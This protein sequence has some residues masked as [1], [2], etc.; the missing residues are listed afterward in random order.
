MATGKMA[1]VTRTTMSKPHYEIPFTF[2]GRAYVLHCWYG[3]FPH[4]HDWVVRDEYGVEVVR[5]A[6]ESVDPLSAARKALRRLMKKKEPPHYEESFTFHGKPYVLECWFGPG[7]QDRDWLVRDDNGVE[8]VRATH[9][10][11]DPLGAARAALRRLEEHKMPESYK[12]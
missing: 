8:V 3:S 11:V 12:A 1:T 5:A 6:R 2:Y 7:G 4:E 10:S 9:R